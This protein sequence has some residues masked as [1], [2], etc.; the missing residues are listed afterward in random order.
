MPNPYYFARALIFIK[1]EEYE[2]VRYSRKNNRPDTC[3]RFE[4]FS[5]L[6]GTL[7]GGRVPRKMHY[8][9][10]KNQTTTSRKER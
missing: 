5:Y 1:W 4:Y 8:Y 10:C 2:Q 6:C 3:F 7:N 9:A